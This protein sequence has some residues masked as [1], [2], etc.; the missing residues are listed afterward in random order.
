M[1]YKR[2]ELKIDKNLSEEVL[3]E[4]NYWKHL[5]PIEILVIFNKQVT[6]PVTI[7]D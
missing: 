6:Q 1:E 3:A 7:I 2:I 5:C 4:F